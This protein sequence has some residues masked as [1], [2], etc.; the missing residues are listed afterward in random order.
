MQDHEL[1]GL[2]GDTY[3]EI[4]ERGRAKVSAV[5]DLIDV[6]YP[7]PDDVE[8]RQEAMS[9]ALQV[10]LDG[11][12]SALEEVG[13]NWRAARSAEV[14][15]HAALTGAI[16]ASDG[17]EERIAALAGTSRPTVRKAKGK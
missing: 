5:S 14:R 9:A 11:G 8:A 1:R 2:L 4:S 7:D 6:R 13:A 12:D 3:D 16:L 17:P 10:I 15:A